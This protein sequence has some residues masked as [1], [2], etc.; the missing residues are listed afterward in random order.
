MVSMTVSAG[1]GS[2]EYPNEADA[3]E[4]GV[5][6]CEPPMDQWARNPH[7][8]IPEV[9][10]AATPEGAASAA[11]A[12]ASLEITA[13]KAGSRAD[14]K[15]VEVLGDG[16]EGTFHVQKIKG[17]WIAVGGEGCGAQIPS[18]VDDED[19]PVPSDAPTEDGESFLVV[20]PVTVD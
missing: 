15:N 11:A 5:S 9:E 4:S 19:C 6:A 10:R 17:R 2:E 18:S 14:L 13:V 3:T 7:V 16:V 12:A 8:L 20:C 1:C